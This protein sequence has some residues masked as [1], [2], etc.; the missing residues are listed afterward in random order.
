M[1]FKL[2]IALG[3]AAGY[4]YAS[5]S[6][7]ERS[8]LVGDTVDKVK[9]NP[10]VQQVTDSVARNATKVTDA[11]EAKVTQTADRAGNAVASAAAPGDTSSSTSSGKA[12]TS[13]SG[14]GGG[15]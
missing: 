6:E 9:S 15:S 13:A 2:G 14:G 1:R 11:V 8:K 4:W 3:F 12:T 5:L 10:R 7:E